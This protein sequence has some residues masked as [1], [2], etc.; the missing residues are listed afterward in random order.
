M[1]QRKRSRKHKNKATKKYSC[2]CNKGAC[3]GI[4]REKNLFRERKDSSICPAAFQE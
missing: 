3:E 2:A 4:C 1:P